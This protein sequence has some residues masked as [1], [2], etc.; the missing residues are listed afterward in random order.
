M[1]RTFLSAAPP[2]VAVEISKHRVSAASI[3]ARDSALSVT[4]HAVESLPADAVRPSLN[5]TNIIDPGVVAEAV[6]RV[7]ERIGTRPKRVALAIP[8][9]VAKV[10]LLRFEKVPERPHDLDELV[11]WQ[12]R[13]AAPFRIE[14]A[15]LSY[16]P[17]LKAA[18]GSTEFVVVVARK[19]I[20]REY[21]AACQDAGAQAGIVDLATFNVINAVLAGWDKPEERSGAGLRGPASGATIVSRVQGSPRV[22]E[23]WLLVHVTDE[24]ATMAIL[25]GQHLVFFR[26]RA[27]D[28][29]ASLADMVHQTAMY[30]EDRLSGH[31]FAR[32]VLAGAGSPAAHGGQDADYLRRALEQRLGTQVDPIDPRNAATLMDRIS[33]HPE[34]LDALAPLVGLIVREQAA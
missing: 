32:V 4:A 21:E 16:V 18:D 25:R 19:D 11:R 7:F 23:D 6:G 33:V 13:K 29:E 2:T 26:N 30:Y 1:A 3:A 34:L 24:D 17:G 5:S 9:S 12:V 15:Q 22:T 27:A 28:G 20:V 31:G 8:D 10:S 14:D